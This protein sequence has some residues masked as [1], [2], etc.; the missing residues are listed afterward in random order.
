MGY[1]YS[2]SLCQMVQRGF[3]R[4]KIRENGKKY[5]KH[6]SWND[7]DCVYYNDD[8]DDDFYMEIPNPIE[9]EDYKGKYRTEII[10]D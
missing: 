1:I 9:A 4:V 10:M 2:D 8:V 7:S 5:S 3:T 6:Y